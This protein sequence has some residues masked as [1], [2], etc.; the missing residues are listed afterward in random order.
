[1][2]T[3]Q[4]KIFETYKEEFEIY[5]GLITSR[6]LHTV[7]SILSKKYTVKANYTHN[8]FSLR[9]IFLNDIKTAKKQLQEILA[10]TNNLG[11]F[12]A[13]ISSYNE[14]NTYTNSK[15][16]IEDF[17][18]FI[19]N[20][21]LEILF[22]FEAKYDI[23]VE[24]YPSILYHVCNINVADKILKYGLSPKTRS[25]KAYHPERIY[26][27]KTLNDAY[28]IAN[29]FKTETQ[30]D[31]A[32]LKI[33]TKTVKDYLQLFKDPNFIERGY[34]TLNHITPYCLSLYDTISF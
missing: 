20:N 5:E 12:P 10:I 24:K 25:K 21:F 34:Y 32:I 30:K 15:Y 9:Y 33:D 1:M 4:L 18:N 3:H 29:N 27:T 2:D 17:T 11:W 16:S 22:T 7:I 26:I 8:T 23:P 28:L 13:F 14:S 19:D 6:P 31:F